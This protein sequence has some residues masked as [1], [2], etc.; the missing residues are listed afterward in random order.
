MCFIKKDAMY[1]LFKKFPKAV[2]SVV[3][4]GFGCSRVCQ[5]VLLPKGLGIPFQYFPL[6]LLTCRNL[7]LD[8][9]LGLRWSEP[10]PSRC[11]CPEAPGYRPSGVTAGVGPAAGPREAHPLIGGWVR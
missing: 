1:S 6:L 3:T 11:T 7:Y 9:W 5:I 4:L 2:P 8:K 10:G